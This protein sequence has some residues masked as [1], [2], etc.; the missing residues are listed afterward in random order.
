MQ[1]KR[2]INYDKFILLPKLK[3][4]PDYSCELHKFRGLVPKTFV[5][6]FVWLFALKDPPLPS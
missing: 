3:L 5:Y 2:S 4:G 6:F 1:L